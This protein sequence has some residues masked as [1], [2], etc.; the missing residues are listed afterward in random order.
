MRLATVRIGTRTAVVRIDGDVAT[1]IVGFRDV[2]QLLADGRM[3][4]AAA[5]SGPVHPVEGLDYAPV[6]L[7]PSKIVCVGLNY[8]DHIIELNREI[9]DYPVLFAKFSDA[10]L[11]AGDAI[12]LPPESRE[13]DWEGEL[14]VIVGTRVRRATGSVAAAAIAGYTIAHDV[15]FRDWQFRTREW[16]Q[17]KAWDASLPLGP[18]MVTPDEVPP[19]AYLTTFLNGEQVQVGQINNLVHDPVFLV[20]YISTITTLSPGDVIITGTPG[21]VGHARTP[22][23]YLRTGD[24]VEIKIDGIGTLTNPVIREALA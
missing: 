4:A 23:R 5:A 22:P 9:P 10:L 14:A 12:P 13:V 17:G 2:G 18:I 1:E 16:L 19:D 6:V 7:K 21:G 24:V 3:D 20:E 11:G 8:R 15:S